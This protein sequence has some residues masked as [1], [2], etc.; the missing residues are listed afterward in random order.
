[1]KIEVKDVCQSTGSFSLKN[2][3]F[4]IYGGKINGIGGKNGSGKSTLLNLLYGY[5]KPESGSILLD[6]RDIGSYAEHELS[7]KMAIVRQEAPEPINFSANDVISVFG[8]TNG[9]G[10]KEMKEILDMCHIAH[11]EH[12]D[13]NSLSGGEKRLVMIAGA[14]FQDSEMILMDEPTTFLDVDK[15]AFVQ[16]LIMDLKSRGKTVV[17][18]LHDVNLLYRLC[19]NVIFLRD[20]KVVAEGSPESVFLPGTLKRI[21]D[22]DFISYDSPEGKRFVSAGAVAGSSVHAS[23]SEVY[24]SD[25]SR[26]I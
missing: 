25:G 19:D 12:R 6:G 24:A 23:R 18:I 15:D 26:Q 13:F 8:F 3:S 4:N 10:K 11:L 17:V 7:R 5:R 22:V 16:S 21:F 20:G 1:M 2:I 14:I 9:H